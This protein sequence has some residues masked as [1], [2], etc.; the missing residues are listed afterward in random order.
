MLPLPLEWIGVRL[1][2]AQSPE[3]M[4]LCIQHPLPLTSD[5][6]NSAW[7]QGLSQALTAYD[8]M[9]VP[10]QSLLVKTRILAL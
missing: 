4:D 6:L 9:K 3:C 2:Y 1:S 7:G 10:L 5:V 8:H